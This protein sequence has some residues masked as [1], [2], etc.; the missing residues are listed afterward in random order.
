M[1][2]TLPLQGS[3][4]A[5]EMEATCSVR[6]LGEG[7]GSRVEG[8]V[9]STGSVTAIPICQLRMPLWRDL[10]AGKL[11]VCRAISIAASAPSHTSILLL[12]VA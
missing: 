1:M 9:P 4:G 3:L 2:C 12:A 5:V 10:Q 6:R 8:R 11:H 7:G